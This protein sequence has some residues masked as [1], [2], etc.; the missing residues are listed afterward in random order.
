LPLPQGQAEGSSGGGGAAAGSMRVAQLEG[1]TN[2]LRRK[3]AEL[4]KGL[5][6]LQQ[7]FNKQITLFREAV[8]I[9]FGYRVEMATDP[10]ARDFK[11]QFVLRLQHAEGAGQQLVFR[12]LRDGRM[13]LVPTDFSSSQLAREV[14]TFIDR[15]KS[16]PAF[17]ANLTMEYF[18][19][20]TQC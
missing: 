19:K 11:A 4:Q 9:L 15:F 17:T 2:L 10:G 16:I 13:V 5:E 12:L 7:V 8:Y 3:V 14:E 20:Q 1:E 6:R 18:Q